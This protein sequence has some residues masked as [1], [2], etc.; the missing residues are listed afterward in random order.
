MASAGLETPSDQ[1]PKTLEF[2]YE[3][4]CRI[5]AAI[6][7]FRGKLLVLLPIASGAG[8]FHLLEQRPQDAPLTAIGRSDAP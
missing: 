4:V 5:H 2:E 3:E 7:D 8:I 1:E 6:V